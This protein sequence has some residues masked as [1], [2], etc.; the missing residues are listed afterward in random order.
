MRR[1][2]FSFTW[3][4]QYGYIGWNEMTGS[5]VLSRVRAGPPESELN[6]GMGSMFS[7]EGGRYLI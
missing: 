5:V 4:K 2:D 7:S 3:M 1:S 6:G